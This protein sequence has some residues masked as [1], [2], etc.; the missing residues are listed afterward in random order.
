[1]N[2]LFFKTYLFITRGKNIRKKYKNRTLKIIAPTWNDELEL[3]D[4]S[5]FVSDIRHYMEY[6][7]K[8]H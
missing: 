1:M 7:I 6:I 4:G 5:Y 2:I 8:K 3:P